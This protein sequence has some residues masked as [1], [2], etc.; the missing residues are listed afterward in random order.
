MKSENGAATFLSSTATGA[1]MA[2]EAKG[3]ET[4]ST[5]GSEIDLAPDIH[6]QYTMSVVENASQIQF[7]PNLP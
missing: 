2:S 5:K 7:A 1:E 4:F 6:S 3:S